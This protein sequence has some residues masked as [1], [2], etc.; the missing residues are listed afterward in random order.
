MI[1]R[2]LVVNVLLLALAPPA[3]GEALRGYGSFH[4]I[5]GLHSWGG[6]NIQAYQGDPRRDPMSDATFDTSS[7]GG[8]YLSG[9]S[10]VF[11]EMIHVGGYLS[12][13]AG[14]LHLLSDRLQTPT[15]PRGVLVDESHAIHDLAL[16]INAKLSGR[17]SDR[18]WAGMAMDM[19]PAFLFSRG[20]HIA[21]GLRLFPRL[22]VDYLPWTLRGRYQV[23]ISI[24]LGLVIDAYGDGDLE[25]TDPLTA[26]SSRTDFD[27]SAV[28][29]VL[30][31]GGTFGL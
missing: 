14:V 10:V 13:Q 23:G 16:G 3:M 24:S 27:Y 21:T 11:P 30:M 12:Y 17:M 4:A 8:F 18:F 15:A 31:F 19:G 22:T 7:T 29:P 1:R 9:H 28:R 6:A 26:V 5:Y 25:L 20:E 2:Y